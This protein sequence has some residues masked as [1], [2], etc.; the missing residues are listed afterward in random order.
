MERPT[1][2]CKVSC[3]KTVMQSSKRTRYYCPDC[4]LM[5]YIECFKIYYTQRSYWI[6]LIEF[7]FLYLLK[8]QWK[9][10]ILGYPVLDWQMVKKLLLLTFLCFS[11]V[12]K[13][14]KTLRK[15]S[16]CWCC[17]QVNCHGG[18]LFLGFRCWVAVRLSWQ[19]QTGDCLCGRRPFQVWLFLCAC[20]FILLL[21]LASQS[22][23][24]FLILSFF[25]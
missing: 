6:N 15:Y 22:K 18:V 25:Q 1:L 2:Q 5:L 12:H 23:L 4:A 14:I 16:Y 17:T 10:A 21:Q 19:G 3:S 11:K 24:C 7:P 13:I 9:N 8:N 20:I